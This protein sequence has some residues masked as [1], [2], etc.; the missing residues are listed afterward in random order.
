MTGTVGWCHRSSW[1]WQKLPAERDPGWDESLAGGGVSAWLESGLCFGC[2]GVL[3][4]ECN[5]AWQHP[6]SS[7]LWCGEIRGC[8]VGLCPDWGPQGMDV[9]KDTLH[10]DSAVFLWMWSNILYTKIVQ[11]FYGCD[12]IYTKIVQSFYGCDQR[13]STPR[14]CSLFMD[15]IKILYTKIVQ[16]SYGLLTKHSKS[17]DKVLLLFLGLS[18]FLINWAE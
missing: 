11:S 4:P 9:V 5:S 8:S 16:S 1:Q 6:V 17:E 2:P 10:Q 13:Y 18:G 15:V 3:D 12:Q 7:A 14:Q